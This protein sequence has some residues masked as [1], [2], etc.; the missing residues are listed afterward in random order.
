MLDINT[1]EVK[2]IDHGWKKILDEVVGSAG[3][4]VRIGVVGEKAAEP[5]ADNTG[6]T[7]GEI[8]IINEFGT[9]DG[10]IPARP[11]VKST[12]QKSQAGLV[13]E[14]ADGLRLMLTSGVK[15]RTALVRVGKYGANEIKK[16]IRSSVP[17][18]NAPSTLRHKAKRGESGVQSRRTL[19]DTFKLL[20][21]VGY[22]LERVGKAINS[23]QPE[24]ESSAGDGG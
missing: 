18:P 13:K 16:T 12:F 14:L 4:Q 22:V 21:A 1:R 5:H 6:M 7:T 15:V 23:T 19:I 10:H 9:L 17:P 20:R 24:P 3:Y 11:F 2:F 8:A